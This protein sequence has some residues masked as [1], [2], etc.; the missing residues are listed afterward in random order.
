MGSG[1]GMGTLT[2]I[3]EKNNTWNITGDLC[4]YVTKQAVLKSDTSLWWNITGEVEIY[5]IIYRLPKPTSYRT[6]KSVLKDVRNSNLLRKCFGNTSASWCMLEAKI[7]NKK[8]WGLN[9]ETRTKNNFFDLSE[10]CTMASCDYK[11]RKGLPFLSRV[12]LFL[13]KNVW[14]GNIE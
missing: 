1:T 8:I 9:K 13:F 3:C 5:G 6:K 10:I 11:G 4:I 7:A 12:A 2:P 14:D